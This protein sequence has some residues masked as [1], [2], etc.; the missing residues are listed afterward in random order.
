MRLLMEERKRKEEE[1]QR[2]LLRKAKNDREITKKT[3]TEIY[4]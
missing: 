2:E 3:S 4:L 1:K